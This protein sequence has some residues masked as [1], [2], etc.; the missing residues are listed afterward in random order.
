MT[1]FPVRKAVRPADLQ[2]IP[3]GKIPAR[4]L[5]NITP[6]G[7][8]HWQIAPYWE[9]LVALAAEE[10]LTLV[11]VGDYR[12]LA[13][14]E[15]LFNSRMKLYPNAKTGFDLNGMPR[16]QTVRT[17]KGKKYYLHVGAPVATPATSN[18]G[19]ATTIDAALKVGKQVVSITTRP[20]GCKRSGLAFLLAV[21]PSLG[22]FWELQSEP[23]HIRN[24]FGNKTLALR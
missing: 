17:W 18:H 12:T 24:V 19:D 1:A 5:R 8:L 10:G 21:G 2:G 6:S 4:L 14:Q 22:W 15:A 9:R 23:W 3:N 20:K 16:P 7:R 13:Q 11:H